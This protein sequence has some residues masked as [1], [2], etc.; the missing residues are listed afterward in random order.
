LSMT[1]V[2]DAD[3]GYPKSVLVKGFQNSAYPHPGSLVTG[4]SAFNLQSPITVGGRSKLA[5]GA[6]AETGFVGH[7]A[8]LFVSRFA[9]GRN[10]ARCL[11]D[12][13]RLTI[14]FDPKW[15]KATP[16][17]DTGTSNGNCKLP[18]LNL[19]VHFT[20]STKDISG[21]LHKV[22]LYGATSNSDGLAFNGKTSHATVANFDY[23]NDET[24]TIAFWMTK[25]DCAA[26]PYE[27]LYSHN[28][29]LVASITDTKNSNINMYLG[30][31][32]SGGGWST[33]TQG[34]ACGSISS[35]R[36]ARGRCLTT[37]CT[38]R[39][40]STRSQTSGCTWCWW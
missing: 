3:Y 35:T 8:G 24:F 20:P 22:K 6:L 16:G 4:I 19:N 28:K 37:L 36:K 40:T 38:T 5:T 39:A 12:Q 9:L 23:S 18:P 33:A 34:T 1:A 29:D 25:E 7:I 21:G 17:T 26:G 32:K 13:G 2:P 31:E 14:G 11:F 30:C 10:D 15:K 27:Y